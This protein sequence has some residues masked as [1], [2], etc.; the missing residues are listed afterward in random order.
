MNDSALSYL[1]VFIVEF[2][3]SYLKV[4]L[5]SSSG[6]LFLASRQWLRLMK[7]S[8][9]CRNSVKVSRIWPM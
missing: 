7:T 9:E 4:S 6:M 1:I 8:W 3:V 5:L 2:T